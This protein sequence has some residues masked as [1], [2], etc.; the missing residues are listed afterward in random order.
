[1]DLLK[2]HTSHLQTQ[3]NEIHDA[4]KAWYLTPGIERDLRNK[5]NEVPALLPKT[6]LE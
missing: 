2:K 6:D 4:L 3:E 1:M 5:E